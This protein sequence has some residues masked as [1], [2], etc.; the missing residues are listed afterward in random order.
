VR[1]R[2]E[3]I[4]AD[5]IQIRAEQK[6]DLD[7]L[8]FE[9]LS[10]DAG[11]TPD[12]VR[13]YADLA[14]NANRIATGLLTRGVARGDRVAVMMRNHPEF[15]E[16]LIACSIL[17]ALLVPVDPRTRGE[18]LAY[19]LRKAGCCGVVCAD[20]CLAEVASV[21]GQAPD[22]AW[23]L[24]LETGEETADLA[25]ADSL[26]EILSKPAASVDVR[27]LGPLD[28]LQIMYT[29]GTTGDPKGIVGANFRFCAA[30]M[31]GGLFGYRDDERPYTGLSFSHG[32]A[33]SVTLVPAL[34]MGL[35]AVFSR[36]FTKSKLLDVCRAHGCTTFSLV[37]GMATAIY[38]Q[39]ERPNDADNPVRMVVSGGMPAGIWQAFER[40]FGLEV[41]E[42]Y[43]AM[44]GGGM[45]Y[46]PIGQGPTG[47][48]GRPMP[49]IEMKI[50]DEEGKECPPGVVGEI[51]VRPAGGGE[52]SVEYYG[53]AEASRKKIR[54]GWNRSGDMGHADGEGWLFFDYRL[55]GGIR[56]NGEFINPG[57]VEKAV[58]EHPSVLDVFVYGVPAASGAPGEK[59]VVAAIVLAEGQ[60][61]DAAAI[62]AAC[63][64][65]LEPNFVPSYLQ[66]LDE[67]PKTASEK[68]Q[69]RILLQQFDP[70]AARVYME[71]ER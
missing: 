47:S 60:A 18:K 14:T 5:L 22:L 58:A 57:F 61:Q 11:A 52:A 63:R 33:Q 46:K 67:L 48:F 53:D 40:R 41:L 26:R 21:R 59:D 25:E 30:G 1:E 17:G 16:T 37:G 36:R 29:S 31:L 71:Q 62:F 20:H 38:S 55:G 56:H 54:R 69:E 45:A 68:P 42:F 43:G 28:P 39:P 12:E 8:T 6:P 4:L 35:R 7:V 10:L 27:A 2:N 51:C 49:G 64:E 70:D 19:M 15:V 34:S 44:D 3:M 65:K 23:I 13:S 66:V 9:H 32:N 50:L 24:L